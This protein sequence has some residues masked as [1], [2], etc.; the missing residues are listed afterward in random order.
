MFAFEINSLFINEPLLKYTGLYF[1]VNRPDLLGIQITLLP[2]S[3]DQNNPWYA[4]VIITSKCF[5][6]DPTP[7]KKGVV[8]I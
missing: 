1:K 2:N 3:V 4:F 6:F 8:C 7:P 5:W